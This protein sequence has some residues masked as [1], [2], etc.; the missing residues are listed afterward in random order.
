[1]I[2]IKGNFKKIKA[3]KTLE[4]EEGAT[5]EEIKKAHRELS[6]KYHPDKKLGDGAI[7]TDINNAHDTLTTTNE[8]P[9]TL[10]YFKQD[11]PIT[12][13]ELVITPTRTAFDFCFY[14]MMQTRTVNRALCHN[15]YELLDELN[16]A[17][18]IP[19]TI[20]FGKLNLFIVDGELSFNDERGNN[21]PKVISLTIGTPNYKIFS[22]G[23]DLVSDYYGF[24]RVKGAKEESVEEVFDAN[25]EHTKHFNKANQPYIVKE[26]INKFN[27]QGI[28]EVEVI[29]TKE[30]NTVFN[31]VKIHGDTFS[32][33]KLFKALNPNNVKVEL[34]EFNPLLYWL[35]N[36]DVAKELISPEVHYNQN[37]ED[38][39]AGKKARDAGIHFK[40]TA[41]KDENPGVESEIGTEA[42]PNG[43]EH[44]A[45]KGCFDELSPDGRFDVNK[46][47]N[48]PKDSEGTCSFFQCIDEAINL[49]GSNE[50]HYC[51]DLYFTK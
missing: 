15:H 25:S 14:Q 10:N 27:P 50:P 3:L 7:M 6:L 38:I 51:K 26:V 21:K 1:M 47:L 36:P 18:K 40:E 43:L 30:F 44:F 9:V 2:V 48:K 37:I 28:D 12:K 13:K 19:K 49:I 32:F 35:A 20:L 31:T 22:K 45:K 4:L 8:A 33:D 5:K 41:Y 24:Y 16:E 17:W 34:K 42:Y 23:H 11:F 29:K 39:K 46:Y